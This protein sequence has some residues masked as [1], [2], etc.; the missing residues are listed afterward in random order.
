MKHRF[1]KREA[2]LVPENPDD[3]RVLEKVVTPGSVVTAKTLRRVEIRRGSE[4]VKGE[5]RPV[6]LSV[7]VEKTEFAGDRLRIS[8]RVVSEAEGVKKSY[9]TIEVRPGTAVRV[10]KE[11]EPWEIRAVESARPA[12]KILVCVMDEREAWF[13]SVSNAVEELGCV[14]SGY[15]KFSDESLKTRYYTEVAKFV[16]NWGGKVVLCGPGFPKEEA[17]ELLK[18]RGVRV[19]VDTVCHTGI[20]GLN[21][22]LK[23]GTLKKV[24]KES[25]IT[26]ETRLVER[27]FEEIARD[28]MAVYGPG[29]TKKAAESGAVEILLVSDSR[30]RE[31]GEIVKKAED[32]GAEVF[33]VSSNHE[34]GE[35]LLHLGGIAGILRF[36]PEP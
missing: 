13:F 19:F 6:V 28:G 21:E 15:S 11:W 17:A 23:R 29:E 10:E 33:V 9:H 32:T 36:R 35:R 4:I 16:E 7:E 30:V 20:A 2:L 5:K 31:F 12:E 34:A 24:L 22:L 3:L 14:K 1:G 25:R 26:E 8:G 27:L 18:E